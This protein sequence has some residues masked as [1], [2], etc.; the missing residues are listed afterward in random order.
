M[1]RLAATRSLE[2]MPRP[3]RLELAGGVFHVTT[4]GNRRQR[5]SRDDRDRRRF[6]ALQADTA[7]LAG[8]RPIAH[9]L[10]PN[11]F[12]LLIETPQPNLSKGMHRLNSRY[13]H[14]FNWRH[15]LTGH[16]FERRFDSRLVETEEHMEQALSYIALNPVKA[17]LCDHPWEWPW[18]SFYGKRFRV[19]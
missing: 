10:M 12:H 5:I 7:S 4:R 1:L 13:A 19:D 18:S 6:L 3:P 9:C 14:Y 17:G 15:D 11:H 8:W 16:L 2:C